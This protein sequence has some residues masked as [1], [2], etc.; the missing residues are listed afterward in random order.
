MVGAMVVGAKVE[1]VEGVDKG[2][3][4]GRAALKEMKEVAL[5]MAAA[6][7]AVVQ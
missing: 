4:A 7:K 3:A 5:E 2:M 1:G 6:D